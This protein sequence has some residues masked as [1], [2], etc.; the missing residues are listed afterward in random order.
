MAHGLYRV[1]V[2]GGRN[3]KNICGICLSLVSLISRATFV[4]DYKTSLKIHPNEG[5]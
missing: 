2:N 4:L 5:S 1:E 3:T